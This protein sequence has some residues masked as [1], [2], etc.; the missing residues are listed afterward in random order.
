M[1]HVSFDS[2]CDSTDSA[3]LLS[4]SSGTVS[5]T[6][7]DEDSISTFHEN[8][9]LNNVCCSLG[10]PQCLSFG[11]V[12]DLEIRQRRSIG[13]SP[14]LAIIL[15]PFK[16]KRF[17]LEIGPLHRCPGKTHLIERASQ[18]EGNDVA[19]ATIRPSSHIRRCQFRKRQPPGEQVAASLE[20]RP[21]VHT[22]RPT[23]KFR[24]QGHRNPEVR[25][26][27]LVDQGALGS[28]PT[29]P[30]CSADGPTTMP[31]QKECRLL[32][33]RLPSDRSSRC[34]ALILRHFF[35]ITG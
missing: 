2:N 8:Q 32:S 33:S 28:F 23:I 30:R 22:S 11:N 16:C 20:Q 17:S 3:T 5:A 21:M 35:G 10:N 1:E 26:Q 6:L 13:V 18:L 7:L 9:N 14:L 27:H 25:V 4:D 29:H 34:R 19:H 15:C 31:V 24:E 12:T